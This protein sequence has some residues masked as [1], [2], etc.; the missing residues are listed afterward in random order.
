MLGDI[1]SVQPQR[2]QELH[3]HTGRSLRGHQNH[4]GIGRTPSA[5]NDPEVHRSDAGPEAQSYGDD[6]LTEFSKNKPHDNIFT[7]ALGNG[8][9]Y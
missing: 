9:G 7:A 8:S 1:G 6:Q 3:H 5:G 2:S 4:H